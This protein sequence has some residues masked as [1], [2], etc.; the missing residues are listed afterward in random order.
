MAGTKLDGA[1]AEKMQ[2][3]EDALAALQTIHGHV[4]R[5]AVEVQN[6]NGV[7]VFPQQ[8]K[9]MAT[10]MQR[11][12][13]GHFSP[14][15]DAVS[16]MIQAAGRGGADTLRVRS[17]REHVAQVRQALEIASHKVHDQHSVAIEGPAD[18]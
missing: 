12:L 11:R 13:T 14:I 1:G 10:M 6:H 5:M 18:E 7:G 4:E 16:A 8:I 15:A 2:V 3:I 9:R 17:L